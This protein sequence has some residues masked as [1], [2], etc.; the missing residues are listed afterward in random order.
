MQKE[1]LTAVQLFCN[2]KITLF[3]F[4]SLNGGFQSLTKNTGL[5]RGF[6]G[7]H[8]GGKT[9]GRSPKNRSD[10]RLSQMLLH[11]GFAESTSK[12]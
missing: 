3:P 1:T 12:S 10:A 7:Y 9:C 11:L 2:A 5:N 8:S 4:C 6:L